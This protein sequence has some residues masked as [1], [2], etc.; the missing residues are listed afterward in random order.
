MGPAESYTEPQAKDHS[1]KVCPQAK[2]FIGCNPGRRQRPGFAFGGKAEGLRGHSQPHSDLS[3][4]SLRPAS[5]MQR[6]LPGGLV[7]EHSGFPTLHSPASLSTG[8]PGNLPSPHRGPFL[9]RARGPLSV[10][11]TETVPL[12]LRSSLERTSPPPTWLS[13]LSPA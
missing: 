7:P 4:L 12:W 10:P 8:V 6:P 13:A 5:V 2:S 3:R 1:P 11:V 9:V